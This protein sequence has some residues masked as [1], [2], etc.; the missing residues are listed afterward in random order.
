MRCEVCSKEC[1]TDLDYDCPCDPECERCWSLCW[2]EHT[3]KERMQALRERAAKATAALVELVGAVDG[4]LIYEDEAIAA[5]AERRDPCPNVMTGPRKWLQRIRAARK[6]I[7]IP[8][9]W[10]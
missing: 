10:R 2:H 8:N 6:T 5:F 3:T 7:D 1:A 4:L 9:R